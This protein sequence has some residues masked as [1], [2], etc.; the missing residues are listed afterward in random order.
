MWAAVTTWKQARITAAVAS[1]TLRWIG[2][3]KKSFR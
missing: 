3:E 2:S 1:H